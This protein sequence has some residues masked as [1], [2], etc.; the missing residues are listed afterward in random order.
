MPRASLAS[1]GSWLPQ[2]AP[3]IQLS[4]T[5][6]VP[7]SSGAPHTS[8]SASRRWE[9]ERLSREQHLHGQWWWVWVLESTK[10]GSAC[11]FYQSLIVWHWAN[12][13][14]S[15]SPNFLMSKWRLKICFGG[16]V[17]N[18]SEMLRLRQSVQWLPQR[19]SIQ[20]QLL[21]NTVSFSALRAT[22]TPPSVSCA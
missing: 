2:M 11:W 7:L 5:S 16:L 21:F 20:G 3:R 1:A 18:F 17:E 6:Q 13:W 8:K 19:C 4:P 22:Q 9:I 15:W 10:P 14:T 12:Y